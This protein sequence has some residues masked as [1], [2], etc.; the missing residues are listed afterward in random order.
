MTRLS[1]PEEL[2]RLRPPLVLAIGVF[3][4]LHLGHQAVLQRSLWEAQQCQ[5]TAVPVTF[6]PHPTKILRPEAPSRLLTSTTH[7]LQLMAGMGFD[8]ALVIPFHAAFAA[9]P[10]STF[11]ENLHRGAGQLE[12]IIVGYGWRFGF[13]REGTVDL[14]RSM[15]GQLGFRAVEIPPVSAGGAPVSSSRIR[16]AIREGRFDEA[17][18]CLG[19]PYRILGTVVEGRKL[20]RTLGFPTANLQTHNEQFPPDGVYVGLVKREQECLRSVINIGLRPT[21][22]D[23][24]ERTLEVHILGFTGNLYGQQLE[25]EFLSFLRPEKK[26]GTVSELATQIARDVEAAKAT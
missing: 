15:G 2:G 21:L 7:K 11:L 16:Q 4:G 23:S 8:Q 26:F 17:R 14:I 24:H 12:A 3:D 25:V 9:T 19:R 13:R 5:G 20:G 18:L 10:A 22:S 6:D 1:Q